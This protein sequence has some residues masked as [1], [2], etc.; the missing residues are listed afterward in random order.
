MWVT[1]GLADLFMDK[2]FN[3]AQ[4]LAKAGTYCNKLA[5]LAKPKCSQINYAIFKHTTISS[6]RNTEV[7]GSTL[8]KI[9]ILHNTASETVHQVTGQRNPTSTPGK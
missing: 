1:E 7:A 9:L 6:A 2:G 4:K 5:G 3:K 8:Q